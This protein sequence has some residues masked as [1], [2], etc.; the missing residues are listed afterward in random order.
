M[1][2]IIIA[3]YGLF[4]LASCSVNKRSN[5]QAEESFTIEMTQP[6]TRGGLIETALEGLFYGAT[7]LAESTAKSLNSNYTQSISIPDYYNKDLGYVEKTYSEI[8]LKKY[9]RPEETATLNRLEQVIR[10]DI[11]ELPK[12][13]G[14]AKAYTFE[15]FKRM[16]EDD[17]MNFHAVIEIISDPENP[18]VSRLSFNEL[19]VLF[20]KTKIYGKGDLNVRIA[21]SIEGQWRDR[22]G[23][24]VRQKLIEQEYTFTDL[25]YGL[26]NQIEQ[27]ILSPWYY[28]LPIESDISDESK[29]GL[30]EIHVQLQEFENGKSKYIDKLPGILSDN[31]DA[32]ISNGSSVI[33][34]L[35]ND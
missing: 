11:D 32:I 22:D 29:F 28:D 8:H 15:D 35:S 21:I 20:S 31:K 12:S 23:S 5:I 9:S 4:F 10:A 2:R 16:P 24:P 6:E 34:K 7:L 19:N 1:Q 26:K 18:G 27:P 3:L 17:L 14:S 30:M 33:E 13:R 25:E